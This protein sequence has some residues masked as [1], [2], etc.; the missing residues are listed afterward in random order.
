MSRFLVLLAAGATFACPAAAEAAAFGERPLQ[1]GA[2]GHDVRVL[3][4]WLTNLGFA[5][6][7]DGSF[8][9]DTVRG[10]RRFER[11]RGLAVDGRVSVAD[12][13]LMRGVVEGPV[14]SQTPTTGKASASADGRTATVPSDAP[15]PVQAAIAAANRITDRPYRWGG[16]HGRWEDSAY[17][18]SGAVSYALHGAG[19]LDET[20]DSSGLEGFGAAGAGQW[21]TVY[22]NSD[23]A[24]VVIAGLRFDTSGAGQSGPRWR[25]EPRS[26]KGYV[27]RHP[28]GL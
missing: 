20:L 19:L 13:Q 1:R 27:A 26:G 9:P 6:A 7:V 2:H 5:T 24:F 11:R 10:V 3:Q 15:A 4:K 22:A 21:I 17:D 25:P 23:H 8:G 16:G 18:C 28:A 14:A 12:A